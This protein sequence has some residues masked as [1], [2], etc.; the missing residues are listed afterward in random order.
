MKIKVLIPNSGMSGS[1]LK[2]RE[3]MLSRAVSEDTQISVDCIAEGPDS[4]ESNTDESLAASLIIKDAIKAEKEGADA[5][6][7]YC[8]SDLAVAAV[9]EN[10]EIPVIGPGEV[11]LSAA[12]MLSNRFTVVTTT[13]GNISRTYR[14]LKDSYLTRKMTSV[15][16]LNIPVAELRENPEATK[17]Y[18]ERVVT[19]AIEE[20]AV[21]GVVLACLGMAQYGEAI[22]K[23][24]GVTVYD[25]SSLCA[26][27]AEY[28]VRTKLRHNRRVYAKYE[29]GDKYGLC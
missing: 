16:A 19:E 2:A 23:K 8:F 24:Y 1:I 29:K 20:E 7:I 5:L 22:E 25:P 4:I 27:Y 26:A 12:A 13:E 9:R 3:I 21:D 6:I 17:E 14:R 10:V 11:T 28:C 18:L 15:R